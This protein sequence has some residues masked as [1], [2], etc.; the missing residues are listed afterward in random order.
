L[1]FYPKAPSDFQSAAF[2]LSGEERPR[3]NDFKVD[4]PDVV[5]YE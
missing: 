3:F 4:Q 2:R 5:P 1:A